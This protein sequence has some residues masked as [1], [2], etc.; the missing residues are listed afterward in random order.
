MILFSFVIKFK[1]CFLVMPLWSGL[2]GSCCTFLRCN[3]S[4]WNDH[5]LS[6]RLALHSKNRTLRPIQL[7][8][9]G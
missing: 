2:R 8:F 3:S 9:I 1:S 4:E 6:L 7:P 5:S